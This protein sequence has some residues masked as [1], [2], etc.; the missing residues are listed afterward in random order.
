MSGLGL[1]I[2]F[3]AITDGHIDWSSYMPRITFLGTI[4]LLFS[5]EVSAQQ[6]CEVSRLNSTAD[7]EPTIQLCQQAAKA[8]GHHQLHRVLA[9]KVKLCNFY[10][11]SSSDPDSYSVQCNQENVQNAVEI[12]TC[13]QSLKRYDEVIQSDRVLSNKLFKE[14]PKV[15]A[16]TAMKELFSKVTKAAEKLFPAQFRKPEWSLTV[17]ESPMVN[18]TAGAGGLIF[19]STGLWQGPAQLQQ[20]EVAAVLAHEA[21]HVVLEHSLHQGC[22][23][24]EWIG[25]DHEIHSAK[26]VF[27]EDI[28]GAFERKAV[29][30]ELSQKNEKEADALAVQVLSEAGL[31]PKG[32][33][34]LLEALR[35]KDQPGFSSG[36]HPDIE[37]RIENVKRALQSR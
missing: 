9:E 19:A 31:D 11:F 21:S 28:M 22:L 27:R 35:P 23:A 13:T 6:L 29:W 2:D 18:A 5:L 26:E 24:L 14:Y 17:F 16:S 15:A 25:S 3:F 33:L 12:M 4:V 32:M 8:A 10:S 30:M 20:S 34:R 37:D 36:S 1:A 7:I